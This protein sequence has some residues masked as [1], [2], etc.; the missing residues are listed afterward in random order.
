[1]AFLQQLTA[2]LTPHPATVAPLAELSRREGEWGLVIGWTQCNTMHLQLFFGDLTF[3]NHLLEHF[4][5][6]GF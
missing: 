4:F 2:N 1:M 5:R 6:R 3:I